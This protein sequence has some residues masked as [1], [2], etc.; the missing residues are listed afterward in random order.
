MA[1]VKKL[2]VRDAILDSAFNLFVAKGYTQ[3]T[4]SEISRQSSVTMSNIYNYFDSK[5]DILMAIYYPW[6]DAQLTQLF[7]DVGSQKSPR[8]KFIKLF[9]GLL[10]VIPEKDGGFA[11]L[12]LEAISARRPD[13][14][15]SREMLFRLEERVSNLI[16]EI[17]PKGQGT[18]FTEQN[19][20]SHL[21]FMAFD[22]FAINYHNAGSSKRAQAIAELLTDAI[23]SSEEI[24]RESSLADDR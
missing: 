23:F 13:E 1:Q 24:L 9:T 12:W 19:L 10:Q 8:A 18:Q 17:L 15:Y 11:N 20:L 3:S 22:G 7:K 21:I 6:F 5:L 2:D 16:R 4:L 14:P